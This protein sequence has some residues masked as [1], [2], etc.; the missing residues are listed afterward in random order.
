M[1]PS[2]AALSLLKAFEQCPSGGFAAVPYSDNSHKTIGWGHKIEPHER[3]Q[4]RMSAATAD[5]LLHQD[6]N[7][8]ARVIALAIEPPLTQ[9]EFDALCCLAFNIGLN[10]FLKSTLAKKLNCGDDVETCA[11]EFLRWDKISDPTTISGKKVC[12]GLTRRR[13]AERALFLGNRSR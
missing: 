1:I 8:V 3:F 2:S 7:A 6:L 12:A 13:E 11:D 10:A 5:D 4:S 9:N